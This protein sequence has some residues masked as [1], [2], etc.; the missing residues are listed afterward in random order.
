MTMLDIGKTTIDLSELNRNDTDS[1]CM[2]RVVSRG[3]TML[4]I[5]KTTIDLSELNRNDTDS[6]SSG[7][8]SDSEDSS[9]DSP[10]EPQKYSSTTVQVA[11]ASTQRIAT[12]AGDRKLFG[13]EKFAAKRLKAWRTTP[14]PSPRKHASIQPDPPD[15]AVI[16]QYDA[17]AMTRPLP[18]IRNIEDPEIE[19]AYNYG[20]I[21]SIIAILLD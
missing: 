9:L 6:G 16:F 13:L 19:R 8:S 2:H 5:G 20:F 14:G 12:V 1:L 7:D 10:F 17:A 15:H 3:M 18:P 11:P 21:R 4:D